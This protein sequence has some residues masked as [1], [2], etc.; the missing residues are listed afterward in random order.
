MCG[1]VD[2]RIDVCIDRHRRRK[3]NSAATGQI[4]LRGAVAVLLATV[5]TA[6]LAVALAVAH[7]HAFAQPQHS[8]RSCTP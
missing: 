8:S 4:A 3:V 6:A 5:L 1:C 7:K 2:K